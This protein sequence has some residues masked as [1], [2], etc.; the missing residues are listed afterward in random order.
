M[1]Q[2]HT[3]VPSAKQDA[4][5]TADKVR[6]VAALIAAGDLDGAV[7]LVG[8]LY[9][10]DVAALLNQ[11]DDTQ[12][13]ALVEKLRGR[14]DAEVLAD[15]DDSVR[16]KVVEQLGPAAV[17]SAVTEL[18]TDDAVEV[19]ANL[20][21]QVR[22]SVLDAVPHAEREQIEESL[23]Y[24]EESA[25]RLMQ[26]DFVAVPEEWSVGQAL[27]YLHD[28]EGLPDRFYEVFVVDRGRH[29]VGTLPLDRFLRSRRT[30]LVGAIMDR[31]PTLIPIGLDQEQVAIQFQKYDLLSAGVVDGSG[32]LAGVIMID[33]IVDVIREEVEED[34][35]HLGG[36]GDVSLARSVADTA[37]SRFSWLLV[38]LLT[39]IVAPIVIS[40][41]EGA[42]QQMVALAVLMPVVAS[43]GGNSGTQTLTVAVRALATQS[44]TRANAGRVVLKEVL[45]GAANGLAFAVI[46]GVVGGYWFGLPQLGIAFGGAMLINMTAAALAGILVPLGL[47]KLRVDP[48]V[49]SSVF[50]TTVTDAIGY[51]SFLGLSAWL[52]L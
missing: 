8:P 34:M 32:R 37:R 15:L 50:V 43:M 6:D 28:T 30:K 23:A 13:S 41:F 31:D 51:L 24:P 33:D 45:V 29:P 18:E 39:A 3:P 40:T 49:A 2:D 25:G 22:T 16:E 5:L 48:A 46:V 44:L 27:D 12:R 36:V 52:V 4:G 20:D 1:T 26:R 10:V 9:A 38:N 17:A 7:R 21:D 11:L 42:I 19:L 14:L 35:A 47:V